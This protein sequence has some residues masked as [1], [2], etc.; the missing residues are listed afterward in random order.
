MARHFPHSSPRFGTRHNRKPPEA[1]ENTFYFWWWCY[2]KR[3]KGYLKT[4]E[5][6]GGGEFAILYADFGDVRGDDFRLWWHRDGRG[7]KLFAEPSLLQKERI[8]VPGDTVPPQEQP[9][10]FAYPLN[11]PR[12][13]WQGRSSECSERFPII[14]ENEAYRITKEA[15]PS[16]RFPEIPPS[17]PYV[18]A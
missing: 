11:Y 13:R 10:R 3:N 17:T 2:L 4:C 9:S 6:G 14:R 1:W 15:K 16:I 7:A 8:L 12:N 18:L 5:A